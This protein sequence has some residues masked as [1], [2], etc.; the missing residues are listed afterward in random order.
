MYCH[1]NVE[2]GCRYL[3]AGQVRE[4]DVFD[5]VVIAMWSLVVCCHSN[6]EFGCIY[7]IDVQVRER[8]VFDC[9]V[10]AT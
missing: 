3:I 7:L 8:E 4:R 10:I 2:F 1:S 6:V 5:C 9:V